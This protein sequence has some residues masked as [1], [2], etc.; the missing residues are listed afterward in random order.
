MILD[1]RIPCLGLSCLNP[2]QQIFRKQCPCPIVLSAIAFRVQPTVLRKV[3]AD[4]GLKFDFVVQ[5]HDESQQF[6][7]R[8]YLVVL[9]SKSLL[10]YR[11]RSPS[12]Y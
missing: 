6:F 7:L 10:E 3:F 2:F 8:T 11:F 5:S 9:L 1:D 12:E 4:F